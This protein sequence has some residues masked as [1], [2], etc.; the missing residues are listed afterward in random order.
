MARF[1]P[2]PRGLVCLRGGVQVGVILTGNVVARLDREHRYQYVMCGSLEEAKA[3]FAG[4][5]P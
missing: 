1:V 2:R 3:V 5:P 4:G